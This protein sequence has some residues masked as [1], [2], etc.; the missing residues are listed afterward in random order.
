LRI[1]RSYERLRELEKRVFVGSMAGAVGTQASFGAK[2]FELEQ[3]LMKRLGLLVADISWQ[4]ARDRFAEH[5]C[6]LAIVAGT[7]GKIAREIVTL[8]HTEIGELHE[9]FSAGKVG[10][11]TM[12]HKRNPST[13]EAVVANSRGVRYNAAFMLECMLVEHE[14]DGA[15][16]RGEWKALPEACLM[17]GGMLAKMKEV[18]EGLEVDA[19]A[20]R[21][22]LDRLG[23]LLLSERVMFALSDKLGKQ[24]AH[25]I[26]YHASMRAVETRDSYERVLMEDE[27][28]RAALSADELRALVDP[29]TYVGHAVAIVERVLKR[30]RAS[31]WF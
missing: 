7:L 20:M 13:C 1:S 28:V 23:G 15:A 24:S 25:E 12:P 8:E 5:A 6:V 11:S 2:A 18:L 27:K 16:W 31:G 17:A 29:S 3:R 21:G 22:N 30:E 4:P 26:V 19:A 10:S 9:P 14:R